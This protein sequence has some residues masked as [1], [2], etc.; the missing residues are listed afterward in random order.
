MQFDIETI[1]RDFPILQEKVNG[2]KL[3]YFDNAATTHKP[4]VMID[5]LI[6]YYSKLNANVHRGVHSLSMRASAAFEESREYIARAYSC[7]PQELIFTKNTTESMNL[8][9]WTL[10][11]KLL[12][13]GTNVVVTNE[14]HHSGIVPWQLLQ[15]LKREESGSEFAVR[16]AGFNLDGSIDLEALLDLVDENTRFVNFPWGSNVFGVIHNAENI[17]KA[18]RKKNPRVY[19]I[20][21][22]AQSVPHK[23]FNFHTLDADFVA[24]SAHKLCGP[25]GV[26]LLIGRQGILEEM[27]P[28]MGGGDMI[29]EV[30]WEKTTF[31]DLPFTF[32]AGT[33]NIADVIA[34]QASL[35]YLDI[36][37]WKEL[38]SY[39][40]GLTNYLLEKMSQ[41]DFIAMYGVDSLEAAQR[42]G[43]EKIP[44]VSFNIHGVH[45]HDVGTLLDEKG[46]AVRTGHHCTQL[47][48]KTLHIPAS[49]RASL[50]FY[51]T[52]EEIDRFIAALHHVREV[53]A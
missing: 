39:E 25:T 17:I 32:E 15:N 29:R 9:V 21:D 14:D 35:E 22:A 6:H 2:K 23:Q 8:V 16:Y 40:R 48:M 37:G 38:L 3:V 11:R 43:M 7:S 18:I 5:S 1:R 51:N 34:T 49:V 12:G 30:D 42:A 19:I 53:F 4:Q 20:V 52:F 41:L 28:F 47:V 13:D 45:A 31:N 36:L 27:P 33:P 26:G 24:F 10:G 50:Y 46:I 44:L